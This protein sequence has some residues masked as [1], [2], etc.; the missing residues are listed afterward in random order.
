MISEHLMTSHDSHV[1]VLNRSILENDS[2]KGL[3]IMA[4]RGLPKW[5]LGLGSS[6]SKPKCDT[7][8]NR[9]KKLGDWSSEMPK[10][11]RHAFFTHTKKKHK[12][13]LQGKFVS[14]PRPV[15]TKQQQIWSI[16][17]HT[18]IKHP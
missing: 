4:S 13:L 14:I 2:K 15:Q 11:Q 17:P 8:R 6:N 9:I 3:F 18:K 1:D 5:F 10:I 12:S 7:E 16:F